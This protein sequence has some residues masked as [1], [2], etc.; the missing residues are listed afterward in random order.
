[1]SLPGVPC[2]AQAGREPQLS[3]RRHRARQGSQ[4]GPWQAPVSLSRVSIVKQDALEDPRGAGEC[5]SPVRPL[6]TGEEIRGEVCSKCCP[7]T[8]PFVGDLRNSLND[9]SKCHC[10]AELGRELGQLL[11]WPGT[12]ICSQLGL[13][14]QGSCSSIRS[15]LQLPSLIRV[16]FLGC[17]CQCQASL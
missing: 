9:P 10:T 17:R 3:N 7:P 2:T 14:A 4:L 12:P 11:A 13:K 6:Q 8:P 15:P 1:M 5:S 16:T